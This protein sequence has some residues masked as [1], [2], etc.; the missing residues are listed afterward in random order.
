MSTKRKHEAS[1]ARRSSRRGVQLK[2]NRVDSGSP[3]ELLVLNLSETG[4]L[5][6]SSA[7]LKVGQPIEVDIPHAGQRAATVV[8]DNGQLFGCQFDQPI[9]RAAVSAAQLQSIPV[10]TRAEP[11]EIAS[12]AETEPNADIHADETFGARLRRLR[13]E[14]KITLIGLARRVSVSKPTMWKWEK[15]EVRPRTRYLAPLAQALGVTQ[16][17]LLFG[18][19][20]AGERSLAANDTGSEAISGQIAEYKALI[21]G[22]VGTTPEKVVVTITV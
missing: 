15:D 4:L 7:A 12:P 11:A 2:V 1:A 8:W 21:A 10:R 5:V 19:G 13:I 9:S 14:R 22:L 16:G 3:Q 20:Q 18:A 17:D 6:Q